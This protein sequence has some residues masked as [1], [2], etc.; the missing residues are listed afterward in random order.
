MGNV[1]KIFVCEDMGLPMVNLESV[2]AIKGV[3]LEG[4]RYSTGKGA[5]SKSRRITI[6]QVSL[7]AEESIH[8]A[9]V[10]LSDPFLPEET[11]RNILTR[12]VNLN[13]L[14][15]KKFKVG[16]VEMFGIEHCTP[17]QRPSVLSKKKGFE[18]AFTSRG[19]LR[20]EILSG[21]II[22]VGDHVDIM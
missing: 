19:G 15:G 3:G 9:N 6:R 12:G 17:C 8:E 4:D 11:R 20:A 2:L 1:V 7:I 16:V 13:D 5:Y 14:V 10:G 21:G 18:K 22:N